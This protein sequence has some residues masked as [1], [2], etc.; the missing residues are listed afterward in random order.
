MCLSTVNTW[1]VRV[2][3]AAMLPQIVEVCFIND[4]IVGLESEILIFA[5]DY[6]FALTIIM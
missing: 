6:F 4:I 5:D 3:A 2:S 1:N